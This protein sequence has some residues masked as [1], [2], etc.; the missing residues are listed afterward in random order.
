MRKQVEIETKCHSLVRRE[1]P[2]CWGQGSLADVPSSLPTSGKA[3]AVLRSAR[4]RSND[5]SCPML[6]RGGENAE[7]RSK[8]ESETSSVS[9]FI[10][11]ALPQVRSPLS[12]APSFVLK[13][14]PD[15][16]HLGLIFSIHPTS[17]SHSPGPHNPISAV[18]ILSLPTRLPL[19]KQSRHRQQQQ[20]STTVYSCVDTL[21]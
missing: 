20:F 16:C 7:N 6:H 15:I 18:L 8:K 14:K 5:E 21:R 9:S 11:P 19:Y 13:T 4:P 2:R 17:T 3:R 1:T 10:I 12:H